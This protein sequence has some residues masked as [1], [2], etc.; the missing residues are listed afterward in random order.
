M[1]V[2]LSGK[3]EEISFRACAS[4]AGNDSRRIESCQPSV[5]V[6]RQNVRDHPLE[7]IHG[8][9]HV[10]LPLEQNVQAS[11]AETGAFQGD[12]LHA[13]PKGGIIRPARLVS[14]GDAAVTDGFGR[15]PLLIPWASTK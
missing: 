9:A 13:L 10:A 2:F 5:A 3:G 6:H 12:R 7:L 1:Q 15:P 8:A 4:R 14:H 11:V